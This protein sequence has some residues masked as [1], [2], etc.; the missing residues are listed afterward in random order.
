MTQGQRVDLEERIREACAQSS[1]QVAATAAF[2]GYGA[3]LLGF[4]IALSRSETDAN[5]A[6]SMF[7]ED[8]WRSLPQ[9]G[10]Q[11]S[12]RT[13]AYTLA[14]HAFHRLRRGAFTRRAAPLEDAQLEALVA[15]TRSRTA[16]FL[17]TQARDRFSEI[18]EKLEPDDQ[19]LLMLRVNRGLSYSDIARVLADAEGEL[20]NE[21][22]ER[23]AVALR[24]RF[25]RLKDEIRDLMRVGN[26][27]D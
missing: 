2:E 14:R 25:A 23:R 12:F 15:Q 7:A 6:F 19:T 20:S 26:S 11:S 1:W 22:V 21:D 5:D 13:W 17:Q 10:W 27:N 9:F 8:L 18:R 16:E 4:L 24:K 3:E